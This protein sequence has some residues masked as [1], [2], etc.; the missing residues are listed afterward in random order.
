LQIASALH[1]QNSFSA[2]WSFTTNNCSNLASANVPVVI[3]SSGAPTVTSTLNI[4]SAGTIT[5]VNVVGLTGTHT[6]ISDLTISIKSPQNTTVTLFD[7]ICGNENDFDCN[8]DDAA[9]PGALPCPPVGGGTYKAVTPLSVFNG[10]QAAG[11]WTLTITD[12]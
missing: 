11:N 6:W 5:D 7:Q 1:G 12:H 8:F 4:A 3:P 10:Q 2:S 9:A